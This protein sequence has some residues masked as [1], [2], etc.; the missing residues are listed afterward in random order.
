MT[1]I[2]LGG[3]E[4]VGGHRELRGF[5]AARLV[6]VY[7]LT[8]VFC[9]R[10]INRRSQTHEQMARAAR[11]GIRNFTEECRVSAISNKMGLK[12]T[13]VARASLEE[14]LRDYGDFLRQRNMRRWLKS[15][16][17][18]QGVR[19][20]YKRLSARFDSRTVRL[21]RRA[22]PY[23]VGM[24][25]PEVVTNAM[26]WL[27]NQA[28]FLPGRQLRVGFWMKVVLP[29]GHIEL[30]AAEGT[31]E[32]WRFRYPFNTFCIPGARAA[33]TRRVSSRETDDV[34]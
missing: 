18:A 15:S 22:R 6:L 33:T 25:P 29:N 11:S 31:R 21:E 13:G 24:A 17:R 27:I 1:E 10:F 32:A 4:V 28:R 14:P 30:E 26:I 12:L 3:G 7:D 9:D 34:R 20:M 19:Q 8:V 5:Q 23:N 16:F 2:R